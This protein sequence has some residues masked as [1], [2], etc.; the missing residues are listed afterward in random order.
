LGSGSNQ[1][2]GFGLDLFGWFMSLAVLGSTNDWFRI[3][4]PVELFWALFVDALWNW[5]IVSW[6]FG[7]SGKKLFYVRRTI[8]RGVCVV[9]H[10]TVY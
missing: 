4:D 7:Y 2:C 10:T 8:L 5:T 9:G 1:V 3:L 6:F